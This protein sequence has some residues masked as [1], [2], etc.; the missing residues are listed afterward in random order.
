MKKSCSMSSEL[1]S[2]LLKYDKLRPLVYDCNDGYM[3]NLFHIKNGMHFNRLFNFANEKIKLTLSAKTRKKDK[4]NP[5]VY[6]F[7]TWSSKEE[8]F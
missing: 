8:V 7:G 2:Y 1:N 6:P 4:L 5:L 3:W